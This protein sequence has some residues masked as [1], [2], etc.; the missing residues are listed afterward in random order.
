M[1]F[2]FISTDIA[3]NVLG[4]GNSNENNNNY[5]TKLQNDI[6]YINASG[7]TLTGDLNLN[8]NKLYLNNN[9]KKQSMYQKSNDLVFETDDKFIV[10]NNSNNTLKFYIGNNGGIH[11]N[12]KRLVGVSD[13]TENND[14]ADKKYVAE[15]KTQ[16][17]NTISSNLD[18]KTC[19][20]INLSAG[21]DPRSAVNKYQLDMAI[22]E[23]IIP[24]GK[25][26][27]EY[28]YLLHI[29]GNF[30]P[31]LWL[32]SFYNN[33]LIIKSSYNQL[34]TTAIE[35]LINEKKL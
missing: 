2:N 30:K 33:G 27:L 4:G 29:I 14:A 35:N 11:Y 26:Y 21:T 17:S 19:K 10:K 34:D 20:I 31:S 5:P 22:Q 3:G 23:Y 15:Q 24:G 13:P 16:G 12:S 32:S 28:L 7:D 1:T 9:K 25:R 18:M 6:D 8:G